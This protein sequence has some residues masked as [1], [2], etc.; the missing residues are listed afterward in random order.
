V[1]SSAPIAAA[2]VSWNTRELLDRCLRSLESEARAGRLQAWVVDNASTDGSAELVREQHG[3]ARLIA[4]TENLGFG[5][6]VNLVAER[7]SSEWLLIANADIAL[8]DGALDI[9]LETGRRDP[10]AGALAPRLVLP[11]GSTQ[12]SVFGFPTLTFAFILNS[13][14]FHLSRELSDRLALLDHWDE[15][16]ARRVPWAVAACLLVRRAAWEAAGGFDPCQWMYAEDLDLGWKLRR[17]GWATRY[18][19]RAVVDHESAAATRQAFGDDEGIAARWQRS[20]YG[21]IARRRG[22]RYARLAAALNFAGSGVRYLALTPAAL[23]APRRW[24]ERRAALGRWTLVHAAALTDRAP[25][26]GLR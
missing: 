14:L 26:E 10:R 20:T 12:H 4:C 18:E 21:W 5:A 13:G 7:T 22:P 2:V 1:V 23:V 24:R 8:R 15:T 16:R 25:L 19:P 9:L 6:A 3:W 11:D 17:A